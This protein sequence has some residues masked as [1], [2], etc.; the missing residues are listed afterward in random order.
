MHEE[1]PSNP[2][3][4]Q[5]LVGQSNTVNYDLT[6]CQEIFGY[7][8]EVPLQNYIVVTVG[9]RKMDLCKQCAFVRIFQ[10]S[11]YQKPLQGPHQVGV[12]NPSSKKVEV[13]WVYSL[14]ALRNRI[15]GFQD[16]LSFE[17]SSFVIVPGKQC[18]VR[19][20]NARSILTLPYSI[21]HP[22]HYYG[23][24]ENFH[25]V[26]PV[27]TNKH[28]KLSARTRSQFK[29]FLENTFTSYC[30]DLRLSYS[31]EEVFEVFKKDVENYL[32]QME[33]MI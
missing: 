23:I 24:P 11:S 32:G 10:N 5:R 8:K 29:G 21:E 18:M 26:L 9:K 25:R 16:R 30:R 22:K 20:K 6:Q 14:S 2:N 15:F 31:K 13:F 28:M 12:Y 7:Q 19:L 1:S 3:W 33:T 17:R 4:I 27:R